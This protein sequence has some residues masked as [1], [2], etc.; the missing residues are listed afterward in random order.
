M[1]AA[2]LSITDGP[3]VRARMTTSKINESHKRK[4]VPL[5]R[6]SSV[7]VRIDYDG[8]CDVMRERPT[9]QHCTAL[10]PCLRQWRIS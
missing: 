5:E 10:V 3:R 8:V 1:R 6:D 4:D 9:Y 7:G 2:E